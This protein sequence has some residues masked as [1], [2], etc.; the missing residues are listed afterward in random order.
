MQLFGKGGMGTDSVAMDLVAIC[1]FC[2]AFE[3]DIV[4]SSDL[5][6]GN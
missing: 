3:D 1:Q 2:L 4:G 6:Y 5:W